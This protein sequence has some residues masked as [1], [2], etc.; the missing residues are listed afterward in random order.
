MSWTQV[1]VLTKHSLTVTQLS[2]SHCG[3]KLVAVSRD[4]LWSLWAFHS[5]AGKSIHAF[6]L[7]LLLLS[8]DGGKEDGRPSV[9]CVAVMDKSIKAHSRIIWSCSW[10]HD[11]ICF[12]TS[13]RDKKVKGVMVIPTCV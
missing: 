13:S 12:A 4:R 3:T 7:L 5:P 2:F 10:S 9:D 8:G 1:A 11:D 6:L